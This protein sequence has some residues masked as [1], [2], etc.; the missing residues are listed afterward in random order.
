MM[1]FRESVLHR[2]ATFFHRRAI[3][4]LELSALLSF[5]I[6]R[7]RGVHTPCC[8]TRCL[9]VPVALALRRINRGRHSRVTNR[10]RASAA[11]LEVRF[12]R[13]TMFKVP[14]GRKFGSSWLPVLYLNVENSR[15]RALVCRAAL[16]SFCSENLEK[17]RFVSP[18]CL[19]C[20]A[21][22]NLL[23]RHKR[24][25]PFEKIEEI[26]NSPFKFLLSFD[27]IKEI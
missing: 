19:V 16:R 7:W 23:C 6:G 27:N 3:T 25:T 1:K 26:V 13:M 12:G 15:L 17:D 14:R 18:F 22:C 8:A 10:I 21:T 4:R 11:A 24:S 9:A 5:E 20:R 2:S